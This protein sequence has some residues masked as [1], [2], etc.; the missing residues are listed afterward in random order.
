MIR[1]R[2]ILIL[3]VLFSLTGSNLFS[4]SE[5]PEKTG[6]ESSS[7]WSFFSVIPAKEK[8]PDEKKWFFTIGGWYTK[9]IGN[10][11]NMN[12]NMEAAIT[13]DNNISEFLI[14]YMGFYGEAGGK[15]NERKGSGIMKFDHFIV[16]RIEIFFFTLS[17]YNTPARL[18]HRS[19]SGAGLKFV[20][21]K[22][23]L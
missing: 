11:D 21:V 4:Q 12:T 16:P 13:Y 5:L 14:S 10:T 20:F 2:G 15:I 18:R 7:F 19:N 23:N 1:T 3:I 9:N 6:E 17:E 22:T 8:G